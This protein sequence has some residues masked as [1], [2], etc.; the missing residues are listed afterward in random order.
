MLC[1]VFRFFYP[2]SL[3]TDGVVEKKKKKKKKKKGEKKGILKYAQSNKE[4]PSYWFQA[5]CFLYK[6]QAPLIVIEEEEEGKKS[7]EEKERKRIW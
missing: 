5:S 6:R 2:P 3:F 4:M 7:G 1:F